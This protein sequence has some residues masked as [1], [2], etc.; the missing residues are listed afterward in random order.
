MK[1]KDLE[2]G[3]AYVL[4]SGI[5]VQHVMTSGNGREAL[6]TDGSWLYVANSQLKIIDDVDVSVVCNAK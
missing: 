2:V 1:I 3:G 4:S 5:K 6:F